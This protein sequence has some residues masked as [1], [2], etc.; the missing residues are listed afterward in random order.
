MPGQ[1]FFKNRDLN[2]RLGFVYS[3]ELLSQNAYRNHLRP[4][5]LYLLGVGATFAFPTYTYI[6]ESYGDLVNTSAVYVYCNVIGGSGYD[7]L[8]RP[9]LLTIVPLNTGS[10]GV[11]FYNN[12]ISTPMI[13]VPREIYEIQFTLRTD[14]GDRYLLPDSAITNFEIKFNFL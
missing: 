1:P 6:A 13:K 7:S 14:T 4:V 10:L 12:V 3:G 9:D 2:L 8:G 11:A 5:P